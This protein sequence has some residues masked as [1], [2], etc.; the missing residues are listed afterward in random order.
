MNLFFVS[1]VAA[2]LISQDQPNEN[3]SEQGAIVSE[4]PV[5]SYTLDIP[6]EIGFALAPYAQCLSDESIERQ[7]NGR[8]LGNPSLITEVKNACAPVRDEA[9]FLAATAL[10]VQQREDIDSNRELIFTTLA[11]VETLMLN[12]GGA[13]NGN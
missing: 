13:E 5:V 10:R 9:I 12:P 11:Q 1:I 6:D 4:G 2:A 8:F 7:G 3:A